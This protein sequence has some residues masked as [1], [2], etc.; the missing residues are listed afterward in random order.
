MVNDKLYIKEHTVTTA[1]G[2]AGSAT[3]EL[4]FSPVRVE[5]INDGTAGVGRKVFWDITMTAGTGYLTVMSVGTM[6][7]ISA[8]AGVSL[9]A[10]T[11]GGN[12]K[13]ITLGSDV[14]GSATDVLHIHAFRGE[15]V[16]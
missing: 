16:S 9:Y 6:G 14:V 11:S 12:E 5:V 13:G 4:G 10:G 2:S 1:E 15:D 8:S 7:A 3:I